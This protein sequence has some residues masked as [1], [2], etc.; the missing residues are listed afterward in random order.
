MKVYLAAPYSYKE[1][2]R[3]YRDELQKEGFE[4]TS[5]WLEEP[6]SPT[7]TLTD[8]DFVT[9]KKYAV[10]DAQDVARADLLIFF[11][12]PTKTIVRA[13]RHVEFGMAIAYNMPVFV[14]GDY[15]NIFHYLETVSHY[16]TW[17]Q[18]KNVLIDFVSTYV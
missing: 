9:K 10:Q 14:V 11:T 1:Q 13:G 17:E 5:R 2:M 7:V 15:E 18:L 8:V 4:V 3:V 6:E 12:D 16:E